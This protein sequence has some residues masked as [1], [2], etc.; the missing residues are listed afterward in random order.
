ML[1]AVIG[2]RILPLLAWL[3]PALMLAGQVQAAARDPLTIELPATEVIP[4]AQWQWVG[5]RMAINDIPISIKVFT[6]PGSAEEVK[7]FYLDRWRLSGLGKLSQQTVGNARIITYQL[8]QHV[9][10][11]QFAQHGD[12]VD[13][14][15]V[16]S[17]SPLS[18]RPSR[19]TRLPLPPRTQVAS[20]VESLD[21]GRR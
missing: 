3:V 6:Y 18:R 13:G 21:G 19:D 14:K 5:Q 1:I 9:Y 17:L 16:V 7:R 4:G 11:V 10:S 20:K 15:L 2:K 12:N 8:D